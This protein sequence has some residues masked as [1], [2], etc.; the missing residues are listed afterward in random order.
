MTKNCTRKYNN[1]KEEFGFSFPDGIRVIC[2]SDVAKLYPRRKRDTNKGDYGS[3]NI[4][5]GC[6][7]YAGATVLSLQSALMSG[8]GY[9]KLTSTENIK[10]KLLTT[11]PQVI[12]LEECDLKSQSI[13][14][15]MGGGTD[16]SLYRKIV[17]LAENYCGVMVVD[18]DGL[19]VISEYGKDFLKNAAS[20]IILTPHLKEFCRL[21]GK[22]KEEIMRDPVGEAERFAREYRVVLLLKNS[23]SIISDGINTVINASGTTALAKG[24]SGD[25]LSGYIAGSAA[26]GLSPFD[27]AVCSAY[28]MGV[29]AEI[30]S[31]EKTDYCVTAQ[32]I[33]KNLHIAVKNLTDSF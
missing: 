30:S 13:A 29:S 3:A 4:V 16:E 33:L 22:S 6:D 19:N 28:T 14:I 2:D 25:M 31:R 26:R 17:Y 1:T 21:S 32:D 23:A 18:A 8:C 24:G 27:A 11:L 9:V 7:R 5:A 12:Y 15:G 10:Y 20:K